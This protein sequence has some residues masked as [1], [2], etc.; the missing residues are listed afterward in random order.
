LSLRVAA[1]FERRWA[2]FWATT[3][4]FEL[5]FFESFLLGRLNERPLNATVL[6]DAHRYADALQDLSSDTPWRGARANR[7]YLV[8]GVAPTSGAFHPKTYF[9]GNERTGVLYVGSGNL[10]MGGLESGKEL[11]ARFDAADSADLSAIR[12][13]RGWMDELVGMLNDPAVRDRW[14]SAQ[15]RSPW[16]VGQVGPSPFVHNWHRPI[17]DSFLEGITGPVDEIHLTAPFYDQHANAV[18]E[19]VNRTRPRRITVLLGRD[20]SVHGPAL[21][22]VLAAS[23]AEVTLRGLEPDTYVHG[24]LLGVVWEGRGRVLS[25][26]ANL[27]AAALLRAAA[28]DQRAN[29]ECGSIADV[30]PDAVRSAFVP[31]PPPDGLTVVQRDAGAIDSLR[32]S[33]SAEARFALHLRSAS[34]L[35]DGRIAV[36]L[37][38]G[39]GVTGKR[40]SNGDTVVDIAGLATVTAFNDDTSRIVWVVDG[41]G[42]QL[43]NKVALDDPVRLRLV[44][45]ERA[46]EGERPPGIEAADL[47]TPVGQMLARLNA[48]CI[49]DFDETPTAKRMGRAVDA[50]SDD[51]DFWDRLTREELRQDPRVARYLQLG[52]ATPMLDGIFLDIAR[53]LE[54]VPGIATLHAVGDSQ[55]DSDGSGTGKRWTPD[56]RLQIRLFNL[57]ERWCTALSDPRLQWISL[58][59]P[60][61]N[62]AA[63]VGALRECWARGY[64]PEHR[65]VTLTGVLL[66]SFVRDERRPGFLARLDDTDRSEALAALSAS[67]TGAIVTALAY[68]AVRPSLKDLLTYLFAWQPALTDGLAWGVFRADDEAATVVRELTGLTVSPQAIAD[69]VAWASTYIDDARWSETMSREIGLPVILTTKS[70]AARFGATLSVGPGVALLADARVVE[71]TRRALAYRHT[72]AC[73]VESGPDRLSVQLDRVF[74]ARVGGSIVDSND[75][76]TSERL[77][78]MADAGAPFSELIWASEQAAS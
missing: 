58:L 44:M 46:D 56:R 7:D 21:L 71:L 53:M 15:V 29:V 41:S 18:R 30:D 9:F 74:G 11:F 60:V 19:I 3:Y 35:P 63:L 47:E 5:P 50:E 48:G 37:G 42:S 67:S 10:T 52:G 51:P 76:V 39:D 4:T 27:S 2:V 70:F 65:V 77:D 28:H 22:E 72:R 68:A 59:T 36:D 34:W 25:G 78:E 16:M 38:A 17:L 26:S 8:R 73:V 6:V 75:I 24:K 23:G 54:A 14:R 13:W 20:A 55:A 64:L 43:S 33:A 49:F 69:R 45:E 62:F 61:G 32:F 40:L 57:L 1:S 31:P 12:A 66:T